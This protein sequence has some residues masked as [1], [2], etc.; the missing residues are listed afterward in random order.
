[1]LRSLFRQVHGANGSNFT[2]NA[3]APKSIVPAVPSLGSVGN[4]NGYKFRPGR[5]E[6]AHEFLVHLLDAMNDGELKESGMNPHAS[7]WRDRMPI[8]RLDETTFIHRIFGGYLRSQVRCTS[9]GHCSN[10]VEVG[11]SAGVTVVSLR[12]A[13]GAVGA[14]LEEEHR[15][16]LRIQGLTLRGSM[17]QAKRNRGMYTSDIKCKN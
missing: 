12:E 15:R 8:A 9:C 1:M 17:G 2:G 16:V 10:G 4:R 6:D 3:L 11:T 14:A 5:Q 13:A 7:G